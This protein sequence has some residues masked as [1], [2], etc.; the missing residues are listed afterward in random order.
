[1]SI[2][3]I[4][5]LGVMLAMVIA[6]SIL[7]N[8]LPPLPLLPPN[9]KPGLSNIITMYCVF[10]TGRTQALSL[11]V[12]KSFFVFLTR[13][14]V[15]G[16]LSLCGGMLSVCVVILLVVIFKEKISYAAVSVL[17]AC[18][19]NLGQYAAVS[20]VMVSPGLWAYYLPALLISGVVMGTLT[21]ALLKAALPVL[22]KV[23]GK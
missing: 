14:P 18:A 20:A 10:F 21:G 19:H 8:M 3:K 23:F 4:T 16:L 13:G 7:E 1:M 5:R 9:V 11:N 12:L 15:A 22:G 17:G 6:L 2:K